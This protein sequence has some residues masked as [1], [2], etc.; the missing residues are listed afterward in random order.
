[1]LLVFTLSQNNENCLIKLLLKLPHN[2]L[3]ELIITTKTFFTSFSTNRL[4]LTD[5]D[6]LESISFNFFE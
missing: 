5:P 3:S 2:P 1:M 6:K 4:L